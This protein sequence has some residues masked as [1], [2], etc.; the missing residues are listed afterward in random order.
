MNNKSHFLLQKCPQRKVSCQFILITRL[1]L[2]ELSLAV[3][4]TKDEQ[5]QKDGGQSA[6][7]DCS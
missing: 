6:T 5:S 7:D 4:D 1:F 3:D 2:Q